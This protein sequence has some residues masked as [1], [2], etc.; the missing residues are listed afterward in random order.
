[1]R[2]QTTFFSGWMA[3]A[4]AIGAFY[5]QVEQP[6]IEKNTT[7][8]REFQKR[9]QEY[10]QLRKSI[11]NKLPALKPTEAPEAIAAHEKQVAAGIRQARHAAKQGDIFTPEIEIEFRRLI[12]I[13]MKGP[14]GAR[15]KQ[16]LA[17]AE[18][19]KLKLQVN[20]EYPPDVPLQTTPP[21][22]LH[23]LPELPEELEYRI[24]GRSLVLRCV[25]ANMI[26]DFIADI[27]S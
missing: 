10:R 2:S 12:G 19:V 1:M 22:L 21:S 26:V 9:V 25:K 16:S 17:S 4:A 20:T 6:K 14:E 18:P 24:V 13:T 15:I 7:V 11:E 5:T 27:V 3:L 23:N 8:V